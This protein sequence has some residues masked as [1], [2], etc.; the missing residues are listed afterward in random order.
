MSNVLNRIT[1]Q[2]LHSVN[3]PDY[4]L[5]DWIH[6]PDMAAV[7]GEPNK[8][9]LVT[10]DVVSLMDQAARDLVDA[11]I[12]SNELDSIANELDATRTILKAFAEVVLD[13]FNN[14]AATTNA[15]LDAIDNA[16]N[17]SALKTAIAQISDTPNATLTQ[18][19]TAVRGKL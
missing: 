13:Q 9:W 15:I 8:Y 11:D 4:P 7:S 18:L 5:I 3:E 1:K 12:D 19:K 16:N 6:S 10:G 17:L 14:R 2:L